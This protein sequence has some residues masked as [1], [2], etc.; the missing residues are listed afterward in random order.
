MRTGVV[1]SAQRTDGKAHVQYPGS[2]PWVLSVGGTTVGNI[3]GSSFDEYR[4]E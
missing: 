4:L 3:V 2:D 1:A